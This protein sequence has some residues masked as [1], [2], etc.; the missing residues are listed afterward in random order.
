MARSQNQ[1][2]VCKAE[3]G[4]GYRYCL[5]C[6]A[7]LNPDAAYVEPQ[8]EP[9]AVA[10]PK[11]DKKKWGRKK[12]AEPV[13][14]APS[15]PEAY[16]YSYASFAAIEGPPE[17]NPRAKKRSGGRL[18]GFLLF[19][20]LVGGAVGG[21]MY[22]NEHPTIA[23]GRIPG[24]IS[25]EAVRDGDF[26]NAWI[27]TEESTKQELL[28]QVP[29]GAV[30]AKVT[31]VGTDGLVTIQLRSRDVPVRLA[32]V[33]VDFS[34]QCLGD[35][36]IGRVGRALPEGALV[37]VLLDGEGRLSAKAD[38]PQPV[39]I[40][41]MDIEGKKLRFVNQELIASGE[42]EYVP[43]TLSDQDPGASLGRAG[44]RAQDKQR[45]RYAEGACI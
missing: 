16:S 33:P 24:R 2:P 25:W 28:A 8:P 38:A 4:P 34:A 1:C 14:P 17:V 39:Y 19:L 13:A 7:E 36:G 5:A 44:Q 11:P 27:S 31:S 43:V 6:G 12:Q 40:W 23:E 30:E 9:E 10:E 29:S 32:G 45:G 26:G 22:W 35:K 21:M 20:I 3:A 41:R 42:A 18:R 15:S 37:Y